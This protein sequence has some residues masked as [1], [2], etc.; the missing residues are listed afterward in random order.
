M[1]VPAQLTRHRLSDSLFHPSA[2]HRGVERLLHQG[3]VR[4]RIMKQ[5]V[6]R[7]A[8]SLPPSPSDPLLHPSVPHPGVQ[9]RL[10][11]R[12]MRLRIMQQAV[13]RKHSSR[14]SPS[15]LS[16]TGLEHSESD[17]QI[18]VLWH[19][20]FAC[21]L[22]SHVPP[23]RPTAPPQ[24]SSP[25]GREASTSACHAATYHAAGR[26]SCCTSSR[27]PPSPLFNAILHTLR[28]SRVILMHTFETKF[29]LVPLSLLLLISVAHSVYL[30]I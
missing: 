4:P 19:C 29:L 8:S 9:R 25:R 30:Y 11:Q 13:R 3:V 12:V 1:C 6:R 10:C 28:A 21:L 20:R 24:R 17:I 5:A 7:K 22:F 2:P 14:S 16:H 23:L 15:P 26:Q 27:I 18:D